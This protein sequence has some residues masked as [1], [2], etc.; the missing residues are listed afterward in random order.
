MHITLLLFKPETK[1]RN[2]NMDHYYV[3]ILT[4][5]DP[6]EAVTIAKKEYPGLDFTLYTD[7]DSIQDI[8]SFRSSWGILKSDEIKAI[9]LKNKQDCLNENK[10]KTDE[11]E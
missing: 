8:K 4:K 2:T 7:E 10:I 3:V 9:Q 1:V 11:E 6:T 5:T